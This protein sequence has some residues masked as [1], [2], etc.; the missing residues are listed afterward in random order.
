MPGLKDRV[1]R[2]LPNTLAIETE[3]VGEAPRTTTRERDGL[4][5][6]QLFERYYHE[7]RGVNEL[8]ASLRAAFDEADR[9][10]REDEPEPDLAPQRA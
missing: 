7:R 5:P 4:T 10:V 1:L 6:M 9:A 8:P 3:R 2:A